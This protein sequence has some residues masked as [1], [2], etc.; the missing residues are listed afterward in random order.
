M[1]FD[2]N[3]PLV[4]RLREGDDIASRI[5]AADEIERLRHVIAGA[6]VIFGHA[7]AGASIVVSR[8]LGD[9]EIGEL[10]EDQ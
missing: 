6:T 4:T 7:L 8:P 3:A 9:G 10:A 5:E 2:E 1:A